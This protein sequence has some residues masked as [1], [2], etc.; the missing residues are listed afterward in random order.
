MIF[1]THIHLNDDKLKDNLSL[2]INEASLDGVNKFLCIGWDIESSIKAIEIANKFENVYASIAIMP[3]EHKKYNNNSINILEKLINNKKVVAIGEI[4]LDYY[5]E[6]DE[7]IIEKQKTMFIEQIKLANK[8]NLPISIHCRD[9]YND[10]LEI[11]KQNPIKRLSVMHCFSSSIEMAKE[12][13]K[14][15]LV[16]GIGGPLTYKNNKNAVN[17]VKNLNPEYYVFETDAPYLPPQNHRGK[18]NEPKFIRETVEF[19]KDL[20]FD[21]D[22]IELRNKYEEIVYQNSIRIF[23][24]EK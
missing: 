1:D 17:I 8:Y 13:I 7:K 24:R 18:T 9:A 4:G 22:D 19:A 6:K 11:I 16:I 3:T 15:N 23:S 12:F 14:H 20:I 2:Y 5:W 10:C 21:I